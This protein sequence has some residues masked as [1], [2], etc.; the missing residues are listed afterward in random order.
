MR[1]IAIVIA[2]SLSLLLG[3]RHRWELVT[4]G[5]SSLLSPLLILLRDTGRHC[6]DGGAWSDSDQNR[7]CR[8]RRLVVVISIVDA[9]GGGGSR[10]QR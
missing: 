9:D 8:H 1:L 5:E 7:S 2:E 3:A 4:V 6:D 10:R